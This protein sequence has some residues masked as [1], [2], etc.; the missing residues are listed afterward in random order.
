MR[1]K[2]LQWLVCRTVHHYY[3]CYPGWGRVLFGQYA[4]CFNKQHENLAQVNLQSIEKRVNLFD[5]PHLSVS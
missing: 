4:A 5:G 1:Q 2:Q 3:S